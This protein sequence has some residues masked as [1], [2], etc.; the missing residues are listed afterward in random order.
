MFRPTRSGCVVSTVIFK[1]SPKLNPFICVRVYL[2]GSSL[3]Q[4]LALAIAAVPGFAND[5]ARPIPLSAAD[6]RAA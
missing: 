5:H 4:P 3:E 2:R 6:D 1:E